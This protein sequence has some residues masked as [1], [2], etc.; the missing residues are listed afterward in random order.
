MD[1][2]DLEGMDDFDVDSDDEEMA[3]P[4]P[5]P[6]MQYKKPKTATLKLELLNK[7]L[8]KTQITKEEAL[9]Y[10]EYFANGETYEIQLIYTTKVNVEYVE[11]QKYINEFKSMQTLGTG[12]FS[13]VKYAIRQFMNNGELAEEKYALKVMHKVRN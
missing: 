1:K 7:C 3:E 4:K 5:I 11:S 6:T 2:M 8:A 13:K 9:P 12:A 10:D